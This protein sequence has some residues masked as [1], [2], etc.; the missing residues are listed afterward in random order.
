MIYTISNVSSEHAENKLL[1]DTIF[2]A[3]TKLCVMGLLENNDELELEVVGNPIHRDYSL[4]Y[5]LWIIRNGKRIKRFFSFLKDL[6]LCNVEIS[7]NN[8]N[9]L[10]Y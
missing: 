1:N 3:A 9:L 4:F 8:T 2:F 10:N 7:E 6:N 5:G